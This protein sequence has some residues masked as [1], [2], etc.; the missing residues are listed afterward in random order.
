M[1][2]VTIQPETL[3]QALADETRLR[4]IRLLV[5]T[6]EEACLCEL[7][8]SLRE[9]SYK[10]SRH[11]KIL[12]QAGLLSSQK[13]GRWVYHR[14]V[15]K[16]SCLEMLY[17]TV[18]ALPDRD[19]VYQVDLARFTERMCLREGGRCRVGGLSGDAKVENK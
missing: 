2:L 12:R 1:Q 15:P 6:A 8:D 19:R 13:E 4:I 16:P 17:A 5:V 7:V 10:L 3:F 18:R 9:P 14:L 11:L